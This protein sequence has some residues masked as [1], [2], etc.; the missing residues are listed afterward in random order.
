MPEA[1]HLDDA[2]L[3]YHPI[4]FDV[5]PRGRLRIG[6]YAMLNGP[7]IICDDLIEIDAY[8]LVSW[9]VVLMDPYRASLDPLL[10]RSQLLRAGGNCRAKIVASTS[11]Q[12]RG[13]FT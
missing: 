11:T 3:V 4:V 1:L 5:G 9:N 2:A 8:C 12:P 10:R 13:R 7:R 6:E